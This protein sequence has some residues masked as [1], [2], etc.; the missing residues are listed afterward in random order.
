MTADTQY[1]DRVSRYDWT[2]ITQLW[3]CVMTCATPGWDPGKAL[4]YLVLKGFELSGAEVRWPYRVTVLGA[5][6]AEQIDGL[7]Y[8]SGINA[9]IEC[10]DLSDIRKRRK[11]RI[12]F[13]PIAKLRSQLA[14]RPSDLIGC[15]FTSGDYTDAAV[16]MVNFTKPQTILCW[17]GQE[18]EA[19]IQRQDF[20]HLMRTKYEECLEYGKHYDQPK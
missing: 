7:V 11:Q 2:D 19:C 12:D 17:T 14:R 20:A 9:M 1:I 8:L 3:H 18:I 16:T 15:I 4:E 5:K 13:T 6:N 10:K